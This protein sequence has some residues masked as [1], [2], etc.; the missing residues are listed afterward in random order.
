M[1]KYSALESDNEA[2]MAL[3]RKL[4]KRMAEQQ[5][6]S[7][8][9]AAKL[10][11]LQKLRVLAGL[12]DEFFDGQASQMEYEDMRCILMERLSH[13]KCQAEIAS[14]EDKINVLK[15]EKERSNMVHQEFIRD[16]ALREKVYHGL[17]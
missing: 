15:E 13:E 11:D 3:I 14:L 16:A 1:E 10:A 8:S 17:L 5:I 12:L 2:K 4:E 7:G 6:E 9:N